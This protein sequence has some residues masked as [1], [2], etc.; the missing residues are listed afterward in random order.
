[1]RV[2]KK[3]FLVKLLMPL[4]FFS[5]LKFLIKMSKNFMKPCDIP[6]YNDNEAKTLK[7]E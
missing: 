5:P 4:L 6:L 7:K 3:F 1:M 2:I